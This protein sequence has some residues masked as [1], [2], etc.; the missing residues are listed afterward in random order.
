MNEDKKVDVRK[1]IGFVREFG[2]GD[3]FAYNKSVRYVALTCSFVFWTRTCCIKFDK[4][5]G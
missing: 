4:R 2:L 5:T 1:A 3:T